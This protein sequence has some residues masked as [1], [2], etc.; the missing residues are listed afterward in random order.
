MGQDAASCLKLG[1]RDE[2]DSVKEVKIEQLFQALDYERTGDRN[3]TPNPA[4]R[5]DFRRPSRSFAPTN[6][7]RRP[8]GREHEI[9]QQSEQVIPRTDIPSPARVL[10]EAPDSPT[11]THTNAS[12]AAAQA[13]ARA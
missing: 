13:R 9:S 10:T 12:L 7:P 2:I 3:A 8:A 5:H 4:N 11:C 6:G 1:L